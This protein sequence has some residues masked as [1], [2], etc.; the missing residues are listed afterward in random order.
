MDWTRPIN[1]YC[2]RLDA[3]YWAEPVNAVTNAAFLIAAFIMWRRVRGLGLPLA[4][5]LVAILAVIG[6]GSFLFHTHATAWA[7]TADVIPIVL[8]IL[9]YIFTANLHYWGLPIWAALGLT[10]LFFPY[11]ALA[12]PVLQ[13]AIPGLGGSAAYGTVAA[14]I[15]IYGILLMRRHP[16]TGRGLLIGAAILCASITFRALDQPLCDAFP[17]GTHFMW[18][19]LNGTMLGWMIEVY[20]RHMLAARAARG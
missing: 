4:N 16:E 8:F 11:A 6:V 20:R 1:A 7:S 2:E 12:A 14:L 10:L 9:V 17:L 13:A 19:I 18:H 5:V 15:V 3:S